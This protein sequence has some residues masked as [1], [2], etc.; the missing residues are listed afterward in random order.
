MLSQEIASSGTDGA[1]VEPPAARNA[2]PQPA[3]LRNPQDLHWPKGAS[4]EHAKITELIGE[5]LPTPEQSRA[6]AY[7]MLAYLWIM[8]AVQRRMPVP[9]ALQ[10]VRF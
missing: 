4:G 6:A 3:S 7:A 8:Q 9:H 10:P 1:L 2:L 5:I